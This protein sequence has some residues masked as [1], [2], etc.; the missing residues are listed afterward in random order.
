[1]SKE[2]MKFWGNVLFTVMAMAFVLGVAV[3]YFS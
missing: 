3:G 2:E 1:M